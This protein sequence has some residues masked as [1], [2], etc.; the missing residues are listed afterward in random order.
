M[1]ASDGGLAQVC[2]ASAVSEHEEGVFL[3]SIPMDTREWLR[4][5]WQDVKQVRELLQAGID[6]HTA[7]RNG[8]TGLHMAASKFKLDIVQALVE[9]GHDVNIEDCCCR[10]PLDYCMDNGSA[11]EFASSTGEKGNTSCISVVG[12]LES[13]GGFRKSESSWLRNING[14][15]GNIAVDA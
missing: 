14:F 5:C 12:Y 2:D 3:D 13:K 6:I 8:C 9:A 7:N 1:A 11:G 15:S 4:A 10:T